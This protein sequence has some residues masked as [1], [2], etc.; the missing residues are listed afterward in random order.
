MTKKIKWARVSWSG[1]KGKAVS[2]MAAWKRSYPDAAFRVY[3]ARGFGPNNRPGY[4][5]YMKQ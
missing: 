1:T 5:V 3:P 2:E 4:A